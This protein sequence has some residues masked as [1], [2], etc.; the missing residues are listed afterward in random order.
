MFDASWEPISLLRELVHRNDTKL[1]LV[2]LDGLGDVP[3]PPFDR[4]PLEQAHTPWLDSLARSSALGAIEP[5]FKGITPGSG[6]GH[7]A[8]FGYNPVKWEIKRG[9]LEVLGMDMELREG[10]VA[11]R[12]NFATVSYVNGRPVVIDRRAGR[13]PTELNLKLIDL[14]SSQIREIDGVEIILK[15]GIEHRFGLILRGEGLSD[16]IADTDP[17]DVNLPPLVPR[18]LV[19]TPE[20]KRTADI[21]NKFINRVAELLKDME[22]A[23][24]VLLRGAS[25]V[26]AIPKFPE[27]YKLRAGAIATYPMYRGIAKLLGFEEIALDGTSL[28]D[29]VSALERA[30]KD[31]DFIYFHYKATDKAGEDGNFLAKVKAIEEFDRLLP[32]IVALEPDVLV[33]TGDHSTPCIYK[34]H[35]FQ[36][37][38]YLIKARGVFGG[39]EGFN[40]R[41]CLK[42]E[43]GIF[44]ALYNMSLML[45]YSRR[46]KKFRA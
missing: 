8:L 29:E 7:L 16:M 34:H 37:V 24:Y 18:P 17:E 9:V 22:P 39:Y 35:G 30:Y 42:G 19:N 36:P 25:G 4:T 20:A 28:E 40:E 5:V 21:L 14:I 12:G 13:I 23:N 41:V 10:D 43:L 32:R 44:P 38:P 45:A 26:P 11:F 27:I 1:I 6:P 46:L 2:V 33:I 31:Y 3:T 15:S